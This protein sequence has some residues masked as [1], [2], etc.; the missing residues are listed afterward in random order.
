VVVVKL[1]LVVVLAL[2][3]AR[4]RVAEHSTSAKD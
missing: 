1:V 3:I 2:V 4:W